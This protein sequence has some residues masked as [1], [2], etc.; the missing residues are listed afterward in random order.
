MLRFTLHY[1][2]HFIVPLLV[3]FL[4][5]KE[6]RLKVGLILLA[7]ILLDLDHFL[8]T[9]IFDADRCSINFHPLHTYW[10][11]GIYCLMLF[12]RTTRIWGI[13]FLIHMVA[14]LADCLFIRSNL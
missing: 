3:A 8:A 12:W 13:A 1:G 9:P 5:F 6:Q 2:I 10:A 7:G 14:D 11:M 4:F